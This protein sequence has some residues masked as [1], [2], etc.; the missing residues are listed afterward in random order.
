MDVD[1][2]DRAKA[3]CSYSSPSIRFGCNFQPNFGNQNKFFPIFLVVMYHILSIQVQD[4]K[5]Q[6]AVA[7]KKPSL[8]VLSFEKTVDID[9]KDDWERFVE[10]LPEGGSVLDLGCGSGRDR[11]AAARAETSSAKDGHVLRDS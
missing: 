4:R 6:H 1:P 5:E 7:G 3:R 11:H 2:V 8:S 9:M 10:L